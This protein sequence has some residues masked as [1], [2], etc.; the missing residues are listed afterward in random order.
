MRQRDFPVVS[1]VGRVVIDAAI[2]VL[3]A[4]K[5]RVF[6]AIALTRGRREEDPLRGLAVG[7][8]GAPRLLVAGLAGLAFLLAMIAVCIGTLPWT[9]GSAG[10]G[11]PRYNEG[12]PAEG[13]LAPWWWGPRDDDER[14]RLNALVDAGAPDQIQ[15]TRLKKRKLQLKDQIARIEDE[16]LPDIIA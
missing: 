3:E 12:R 5:A 9:L 2:V 10:G 1:A 16:L 11:E 13:R 14:L 7:S 8:E 6:D 15:L 4:D